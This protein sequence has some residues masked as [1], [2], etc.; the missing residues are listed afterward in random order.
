MRGLKIGC[1]ALALVSGSALANDQALP[2]GLSGDWGGMRTRLQDDGWQFQVRSLW[3]GADNP[4]GG[5]R[6]AAAGAGELDFATLAD[7]GKLIG[8]AGGTLEA[9]ITDRF[10]A[11]LVPA[12]GI[13]TLMQVQ[14]V[15]GRGEIWRLTLLSW[16]QSLFDKKLNIELGRMNPGGDFDIFACNFQNLN[17]CGPPAGAIDGDYWFDSPVSQWGARAKVN[18]SDSFNVEAGVYQVNP[19]NLA[20]GFTFD[21]SGGQGALIPY[22][23][24]WKPKLMGDLPGIFQVGGWYSTM[25]AADVFYDVNR[26]PAAA[27]GLSPLLDRGRSGFFFSAHQQLTGEAPADKA[28]VGTNGKGLTVFLNYT[29]SDRRTS[30]LDS[31]FA[32]GAIYKGALASRP[33]DE[34]ALAFGTTHVNGRVALGE[35]LQGL[36]AVQHTEFVTELDY[37]AILTKGAELSPNLQFITD[38]GGVGAR[39]AVLVVGLKAT[40]SL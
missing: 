6:Q 22:T 32:V 10:G 25:S 37:R 4:A 40:V 14:E 31:Q 15:W 33:D 3:E 38:P 27:T 1:V 7:L 11:N 35:A 26:A 23:V 12:A 9:K 18:I 16:S 28:P 2:P 5:L 30:L 13:K 34:I 20:R 19:R 39:D 29:Q 21:F 8:D 17:F 36:P 24:E